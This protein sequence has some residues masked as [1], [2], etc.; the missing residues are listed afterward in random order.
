MPQTGSP[1]AIIACL[2]VSLSPP[3]FSYLGASLAGLVGCG[4]RGLVSLLSLSALPSSQA[5]GLG[6]AGLWVHLAWLEN[7]LI[8]RGYPEFSLCGLTYSNIL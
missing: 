4:Y 6:E 5:P 1:Y 3:D 8:L 2:R 7:S